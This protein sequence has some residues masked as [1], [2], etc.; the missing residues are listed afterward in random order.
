MRFYVL[1]LFPGILAGAVSESILG[2]AIHRE[3]VELTLVDIRDFADNRH[4]VVDD[5]PYG[6]GPGMVMKPEPIFGALE[7]LDTPPGV[8]ILLLTPQ[9]ETF[10]QELARELSEG[11]GVVLICGRY[12]GIDERV[13]EGLP[14]RE[15]SVGDYVLTGGEFAALSIIDAVSRLVPGVLG[16]QRSPEEETFSR[17]LLEYPQ[18]TRPAQFR[19]MRVP[20]VLL[21]GNHALIERWRRE[22][23][24]LR[25]FLKRPDL[26]DRAHLDEDDLKFIESL[27]KRKNT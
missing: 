3:L 13:R 12:E 6:G 7:S 5:Y 26:L 25:T 17:G 11:P 15:V 21:S 16:E 19:G 14:V 24:L 1:T 20:D 9:G 27:K 23:S 4:K 10:D 22:Q 2:R 8:P 18:Y